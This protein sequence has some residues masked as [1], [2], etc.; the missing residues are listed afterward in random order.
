M[1]LEV[2]GD[3]YEIELHSVPGN[4]IMCDLIIGRTLFQTCAKLH[5][6]PDEIRISKSEVM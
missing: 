4:T 5:V 3:Q 6:K 2:E 1:N